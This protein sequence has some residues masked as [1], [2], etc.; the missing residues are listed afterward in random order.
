VELFLGVYQYYVAAD[1]GY[2][3]PGKNIVIFPAQ[4]AEK[5]CLSRCYQ[6]NEPS[7]IIVKLRIAHIAQP[8]AGV[9]VYDLLIAKV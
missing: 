6:R 5:L 2:A 8:K 9:H 3:G 7:F 1:A 4:Q